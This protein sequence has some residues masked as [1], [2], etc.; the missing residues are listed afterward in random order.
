MLSRMQVS[1]KRILHLV[2]VLAFLLIIPATQ[3]YPNGVG[4]VAN[5]GC[6]CHGVIQDSTDIIVEGLPEKFESNTSYSGVIRISNEEHNL[7]NNSISGGFRMLSSHGEL[8]FEDIAQTQILDEGWTHTEEGNKFREWNF[9]WTSP[10][11]NTSY[12]EFKIYGNAVDGNGNSYGDA[13]N[14]LTLKV[15]GVQ[16][17]DD[18]NTES[19]LY[20]FEFYE[21]AILA[22][23]SLAIIILA[24]RAIK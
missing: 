8:V 3:S 14:S 16:N 2:I 21:K 6:I 7:S 18:L 23:V 9:T 15:P 1:P 22:I 19:S 11:D 12:V 24:Y 5:N 13:W 10:M 4:E 17:F 20:E